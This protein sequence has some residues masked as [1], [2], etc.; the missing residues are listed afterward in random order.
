MNE[1]SCLH[2]RG[3]KRDLI[4]ALKISKSPGWSLGRLIAHAVKHLPLEPSQVALSL[5]Y[6]TD[7]D[8]QWPP[9]VCAAGAII[10]QQAARAVCRNH[11]A[12][13]LRQSACRARPE[14]N[15]AIVFLVPR[16]QREGLC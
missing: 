12:R 9:L 5:T 2:D 13:N 6:F 10:D 15:W 14:N 11:D 7:A 3:T 4:D 1:G 8:A 16:T